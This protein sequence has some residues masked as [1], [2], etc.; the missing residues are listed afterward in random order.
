MS[1]VHDAVRLDKPRVVVLGSGWASASFMKALPKHIKD[2]YEVVVVSP[3]NYFL[4]TP[5]LPA[6]A[7]G[8]MEERSIVEPVRNLVLGKGDYYE[9][10]AKAIDVQRK[11]LVACF[12][13]DAG[14]DEACF[15]ISYDILIVGVGSVNNTFGI[16]GVKEHCMFFKSI[17]DASALRRRISECF[18]RA[19]LPYTPEEERKRLLSF[20]VCGGGPTGVEV[21]AEM[22]DMIFDDLKEHYPELMKDV[23]IRIIELM[24]HVLSTYDRKISEY[25]AKRFSRA[26]IDLVLNSRVVGVRDGHVSV[27]NKAGEE[28]EIAFGA[29]VW[30]TGIAMNPLV[31]EIQQAFPEQQTH[32]RSLLTDEYL[33]VKGSDGSIWAFGDAAT[34]DQPRALQRADE[35]FEQA[36]VDKNGRVSLEELQRLMEAASK[37]YSHFEEH[38]KF[39]ERKNSRW[40]GRHTGAVRKLLGGSESSPVI[41]TLQTLEEDT[42]LSKEE[43]RKLLETIDSGLRALP[44]T[45]QVAKQE[46]E[47]LASIL[48]SGKFDEKQNTFDLPE[49]TGPFKYFHKG[50][51]AYVG[52]DQAVMDIPKVGPIFG[53]EAGVMWKGYE[54]FAQISLRNQLLVANDWVRTKLFGRDISR[55]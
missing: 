4:Y 42:E 48:V 19:A 34:I 18:E 47:Y 7:V 16:K 2:K 6:V 40:I 1:S 53:R 39:L 35:L 13:K 29:C 43:F 26:G 55:V 49:K 17:E 54:T 50:S 27:V 9:A 11:E 21:A 45:A 15:K 8:T 24:D 30:A 10:V 41:D 12:P 14:L 31:K 25:T 5:L 32:F 36:D 44:A 3:R 46:G 28:S 23:K 37:E 51:L 52:G 38:A 22:H 20:V 33:R